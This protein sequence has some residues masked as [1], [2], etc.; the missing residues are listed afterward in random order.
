MVSTRKRPRRPRTPAVGHVFRPGHALVLAI[1][2]PPESDLIGV[3]K[4][5]GPSYRYDSMPPP[6][7]VTI[8]RDTEHASSVL[9]PVLAE[10]PPLPTQPVPLEQQAGLQPVK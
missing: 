8:L 1:T 9:L 4:S 3:T 2:R 6:G 7:K 5:G 10:L